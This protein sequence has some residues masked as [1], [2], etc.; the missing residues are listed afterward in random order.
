[1]G[2]RNFLDACTQLAQHGL[3]FAAHVIAVSSYVNSGLALAFAC[4]FCLGVAGSALTRA[5]SAHAGHAER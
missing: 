3:S 2:L 1:M 5:G 4:S